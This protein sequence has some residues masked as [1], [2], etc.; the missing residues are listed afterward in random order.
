M[1]RQGEKERTGE[2]N[3]E[4]HQE[5]SSRNRNTRITNKP[6]H[7]K[8]IHILSLLDSSPVSSTS[9]STTQPQFYRLPDF[10]GTP[11]HLLILGF[12][13]PEYDY[14]SAEALVDDIRIDCEVAKASL[15]REKY[16]AF[17]KDEDEDE[18]ENGDER[19]ERE[20]RWLRGF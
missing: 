5:K 11:L 17:M 16:E 3:W 8:E 4:L 14:V 13:R 7:S 20:R 10:Y 19:A 2:G 9:S 1:E 6:I 18:N 15:A 12:I